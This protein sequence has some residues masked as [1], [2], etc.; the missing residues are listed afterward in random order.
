MPRPRQPL[1]NRDRIVEVAASPSSTP[2]GLDALSTRRLAAELG[3]QRALALQPLRHERRH[4]RRRRGRRR[5][6]RSTYHFSTGYDWQEA[7]PGSGPHSYRAALLAHPHIVPVPGA[8]SRSCASSLRIAD[9]VYGGLVR[10]GWPPARATP[11][12]R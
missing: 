9:A 10:A 6:Q 12:A 5:E 1:L 2:K 7:P 8:G 4:P 11:L 3:V